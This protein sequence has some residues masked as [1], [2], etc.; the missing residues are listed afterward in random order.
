MFEF[1]RLKNSRAT[2]TADNEKVVCSVNVQNDEYERFERLKELV[3]GD[4]F[5]INY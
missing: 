2:Y 5:T 1:K 3:K 4:D